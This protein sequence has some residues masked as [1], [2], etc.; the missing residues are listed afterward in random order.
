M[1]A[2]FF[3]IICI[4]LTADWLFPLQPTHLNF[5]IAA[6]N[7]HAYNYGLRGETDPTVFKKIADEVLVPEFTP[8]SGIKVQISE[9][10]PAPQES[11]GGKFYSPN[12]RHC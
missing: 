2:Y 1:Y 8:K 5:I 4:F 7:L 3:R 9:N 11:G 10:D 6:A 12:S